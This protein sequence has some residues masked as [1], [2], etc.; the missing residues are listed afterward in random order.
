[1]SKSSLRSKAAKSET[2]GGFL[3]PLGL[4]SES[5]H[6]VRA[7]LE[8][9]VV[10]LV[11]WW[12]PLTSMTTVRTIKETPWSSGLPRRALGRP[13]SGPA[14]RSTSK[15]F[16]FM[17]GKGCVASVVHFCSRTDDKAQLIHTLGRDTYSILT[18]VAWLT[19]GT[20]VT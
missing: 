11:I 18:C 10:L 16:K 20:L 9:A 5:G 3:T 13:K 2:R 6:E 17:F 7:A 19:K 4:S 12:G 15:G 14:T 1:M 8:V